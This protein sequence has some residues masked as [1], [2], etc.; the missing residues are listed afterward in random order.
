MFEESGLH[1]T[2]GRLLHAELAAVDGTKVMIIAYLCTTDGGALS[3]NS[4]HTDLVWAPHNALPALE[5][6]A[7]VAIARGLAD[8]Q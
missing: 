3:M 1:V 4:E 6:A 5:L 7:Y 2:P 8:M